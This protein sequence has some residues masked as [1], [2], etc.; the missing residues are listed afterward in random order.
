M[1]YNN[2]LWNIFE[3]G[4]YYFIDISP[5]Y[6][7]KLYNNIFNERNYCNRK[8]FIL[9]PFISDYKKIVL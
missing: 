4:K 3:E 6:I 7:A 5:F 8:K 9:F 1:V 2:I